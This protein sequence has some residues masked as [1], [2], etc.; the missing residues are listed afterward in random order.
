MQRPKIFLMF[1]YDFPSTNYQIFKFNFP[2]KNYPP[3]LHPR[4]LQ[5]PI[6]LAPLP[7]PPPPT[8]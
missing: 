1:F 3:P 4:K 5:P 6:A 7:P 8:V 2:E